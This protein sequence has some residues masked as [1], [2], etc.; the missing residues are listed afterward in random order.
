[1]YL[2]FKSKKIL[3][4]YEKK[5]KIDKERQLRKVNNGKFRFIA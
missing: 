2:I 5:F 3:Q 4:K 1:M